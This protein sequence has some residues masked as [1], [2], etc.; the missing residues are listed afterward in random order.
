MTPGEKA[1]YVAE[2]ILPEFEARAEERLAAGQKKGGAAKAALPPSGGSVQPAAAEEVTPTPKIQ[3]RGKTATQEAARASGVPARS[4]E[5]AK[6]KA[7]AE[8]LTA[9]QRDER[10]RADAFARI[11]KALGKDAPF[12]TATR[13]K[14]QK[15]GQGQGP[16]M[17]R[18][19]RSLVQFSKL[20]KDEMKKVEGLLIGTE[21]TLARA[22][23]WKDKKKITEMSTLRNLTFIA[24]TRENWELKAQFGTLGGWTVEIYRTG[25]K[26]KP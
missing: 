21:M 18:K 12:F 5:R 26:T 15:T 3:K 6:A 2:H 22:I 4:I 9:K 23:Q 13:V 10:D 1:A 14:G 17:L 19:T 25:M 7:K 24:T 8:K 20:D 11:E 16:Q